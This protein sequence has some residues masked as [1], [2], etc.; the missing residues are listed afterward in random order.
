MPHVKKIPFLL[1][2]PLLM[3]LS[4]ACGLAAE[5]P[6]KGGTQLPTQT[7]T[8]VN[9][10]EMV[11]IAEEGLNIRADHSEGSADIGDL[12]NG[13]IVTCELP[14]TVVAESVWCK[15][16]L[17]WSNARWLKAVR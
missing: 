14:L 9:F 13:D 1:Y 3:S 11:V 4:L 16:R 8:A 10:I 17:G 12:F 6:S 5:L 2:I 7:S 15:H